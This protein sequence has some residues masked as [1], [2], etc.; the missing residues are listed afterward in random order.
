MIF[1][2]DIGTS[3][4]IQSFEEQEFDK[5]SILK[6]FL[7]KNDIWNLFKKQSFIFCCFLFLLHW[8]KL[9]SSM[10]AFVGRGSRR[11]ENRTLSRRVQSPGAPAG[12]GALHSPP[13][14]W[15]P[16][17]NIHWFWRHLNET[18]ILTSWGQ[19][20]LVSGFPSN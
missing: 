7:D 1:F 8:S 3:K 17:Y 11:R 9:K 6:Y 12:S 4:N 5:E 20:V 19:K 15:S 13:W 16:D 2:F 14:T 10:P 18:G